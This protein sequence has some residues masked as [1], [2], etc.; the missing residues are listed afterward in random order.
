[1]WTDSKRAMIKRILLP[2]DG[3]AFSERAFKY[4]LYIAKL[5]GASI[6]ALH[7]VAVPA[8]KPLDT[9]SVKREM[10]RQAEFVLMSVEDRAKA[11]RVAIETKIT[12]ARSVSEAILQEV[13]ESGC[14]LIVI[15]SHGLTGF[16]KFL[17]GSVSEA[18]VKGASLPV[19]VV[20]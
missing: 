9:S 15:G 13:Q 10:I 2:T 20:R 5:S 8:P 16:R 18:V 11:E 19:L 3:S 6:V 12:A 14:D 17:L 7:V 4:A 1:M